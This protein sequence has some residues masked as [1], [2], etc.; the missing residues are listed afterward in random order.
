MA[1]LHRKTTTRAAPADATIERTKTGMI[2]KWKGRGGRTRTGVVVLNADGTPK[3]GPDGRL[4]VRTLSKTLYAK[5]GSAVSA[6]GCRDAD[7]ARFRLGELVRRAEHRRA[8]IL[9][10]AE[11]ATADHQNTP[12][13]AHIDAYK[14]SLSAKGV[15]PKHLKDQI[16]RVRRIAKAC[17][18]DRLSA[19]TRTGLERVLAQQAESNISPRTR[20]ASLGAMLAFARWAVESGRCVSN[21]FERIG[22][23]DERADRRVTR[24]A[25]TQDEIARLLAAT[26]KRPIAEFGRETERP[27]NPGD[28]DAKQWT[29]AALTAETLDAAYERGLVA[30]KDNPDLLTRLARRGRERALLWRTMLQTGLRANETRT[31][32]VAR[33]TLTGDKPH[34]A[35]A[36]ANAKNRQAATIPLRPD[37]AASLADHVAERLRIA[38]AEARAEGLAIPMR[39]PPDALLFDAPQKLSKGFNRDLE[40]AGVAKVDD[41]G[42]VADVHAL[43]MTFATMLSAAGVS[44]RTAQA[45]MR[46]SDPRLTANT[47]T[48]L[49]L[50]DTAAAV[51]ALPPLTGDGDERESATGTCDATRESGAPTLHQRLHHGRAFLG[52]FRHSLTIS[53]A[54]ACRSAQRGG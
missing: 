12:L 27:E 15:T 8:D 33:C 29:K 23:A 48:D 16:S 53:T 41:R 38:Q 9:T 5:V 17:A 6:T 37:L 54:I 47:Y 13:S 1:S 2:A 3:R 31:L 26:R 49:K 14:A 42:R 24:R 50:I 51:D 34:F 40:A 43:R 22:K 36:A 21:P 39:L 46:H 25:L 20:N 18:F 45:C 11:A 32:T 10:A 35:L 4:R 19:M 52:V 44:L 30:L 28:A 7:A